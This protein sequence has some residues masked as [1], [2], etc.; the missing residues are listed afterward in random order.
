MSKK[1]WLENYPEGVPH[2]INCDEYLSVRDMVEEKFSA[3]KD[4]H[5][6]SNFGCDISF[7]DVDILSRKF[8]SFLQNYLGLKKGDRFCYLYAKSSSIS[9]CGFWCS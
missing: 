2:E 6:F 4:C 3:Y 7:E 5:A 8:A 1:I 9:D